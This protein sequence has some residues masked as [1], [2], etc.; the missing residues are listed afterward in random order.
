M[1]VREI[2]PA[3]MQRWVN[4]MK[5]ID[6]KSLKDGTRAV[7]LATLDR[8]LRHAVDMGRLA[9]VPKLPRHRKPKPSPAR[10]RVLTA[11]EEAALLDAAIKWLRP[12]IQVALEQALRIGEVCGLRWED[13]D[14]DTNRLH[15]RHALG[16]DGKLGPTKGRKECAI[17]LRPEARRVLLEA[18]LAAGQPDDG[19]LFKTGIGTARGHKQVSVAYVK[20]VKAA[21]L[22]DSGVCFH[23]LRHTGITR[24]GAMPNMTLAYLQKF[25]RHANAQITVRYL[26]THGDAEVEDQIFGL[27]PGAAVVEKLTADYVQD[28]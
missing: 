16:R 11:E 5:R 7:T 28:G 22:A 20:A 10:D 23:T 14:F 17:A 8:L 6:G 25:A 3:V 21:G 4:G 2:N 24:A 9:E 1:K 15:V 27:W 12:M 26:H 18:W 19:Y 13:V